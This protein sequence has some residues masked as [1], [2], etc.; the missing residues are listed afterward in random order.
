M[1]L[2]PG[3]RFLASRHYNRLMRSLRSLAIAALV[4]S[5][6]AAPALTATRVLRGRV[7]S[8]ADGDT[9]T[10]LDAT[11]HTSRI[12]LQGIDAPERGQDFGNLSRSHLD[13]LV[14]RREV[15]VEITKV[16]DYG[17]F[18]GRVLIGDTDAGLEQIRAGLAWFYAHYENELPPRDRRLYAEAHRRARAARAGLW[19]AADPIPPWQFRRLA[20]RGEPPSARRAPPPEPPA[21][22]L[23]GKVIANRRSHLYHLPG[24][25]GW[26]EVSPHNRVVFETEAE[27]LAAGYRR[28]RNCR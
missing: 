3:P 7:V 13:R 16:D 15:T 26:S 17:R 8:V 21:A 20:R 4:L 24:C 22:S 25:P 19:A 12:R 14:Y 9:I 1:A 6:L 28:A 23:A 11:K 5:G 2:T 27:A 10:I 18:V